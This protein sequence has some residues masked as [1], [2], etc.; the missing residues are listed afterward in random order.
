MPKFKL[1]DLLITPREHGYA[2]GQEGV[3]HV[4]FHERHDRIR[5]AQK[6][7]STAD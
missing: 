5:W 4:R 7:L 1:P 3:V 6:A 2:R